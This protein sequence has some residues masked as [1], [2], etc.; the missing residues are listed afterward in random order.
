MRIYVGNLSHETTAGDIRTEFDAFGTV[1]SVQVIMDRE[2]G[3][4]KGFAFVSMPA[5]SEGR[6]AINGLNGKPLKGRNMTVNAAHDTM[7][8]T[9]EG[10]FRRPG[11]K[12]ENLCW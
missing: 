8:G 7:I 4:P 9:A 2:N 3:Q 12:N 5:S 1:G 6:A 11:G 10:S